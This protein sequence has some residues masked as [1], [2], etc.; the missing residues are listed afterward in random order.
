MRT[1]D[2]IRQARLMQLLEMLKYG[3]TLNDFAIR[4]KKS[5]AQV[6]Q[7]KNRSKRSNG[8]LSNIDSASA[9]KIEQALHLE[10]G[11]MDNDPIHDARATP[12]GMSDMAADVARWFD[13]MADPS[14]R[15]RAYA[16]IS[17]MLVSGRWPTMPQPGLGPI[18]LPSP[19]P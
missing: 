6:S 7:W 2:E 8:G 9:R 5:P 17:Q 4:I 14:Q 13:S 19:P 16:I 11:W 15:D 3:R 18:A 12:T 10:T 1:I